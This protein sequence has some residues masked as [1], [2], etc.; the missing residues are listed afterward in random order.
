MD[1]N[2]KNSGTLYVCAT[3]IGN[4]ED[5]TLR[6]L[7][8]L[9]EVDIIAAEDT[10]HTRKLLS[11]YEISAQLTSYHEH[12]KAVATVGLV[13]KLREGLDVALVSDAGMPGISDPGQELIKACRENGIAVTVCPGASAGIAGLVLSGICCGRY[14]FEGFLPRGKKERRKILES[15]TAEKRTI[16]L[17]EA[18]HRLRD[19]LRDMLACLGDRQVAAVREITKKFE[20]VRK[21]SVADLISHY[22]VD[23]PRGEFVLVIEGFAGEVGHCDDWPDDLNEHMELYT[24]TGHDE[25]GAM[26]MVAK[27]RGIP[28]SAVYSML[29]IKK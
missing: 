7:R 8:V 1:S 28:K 2:E 14:V 4:L 22:D 13:Q 18:P 27:D 16:V 20:E 3:P 6:V 19:T 21:S 12:N 24:S 29:K 5:I 17:Y 9:R 15:L 23:L 25:K 10:R 26:K 11:F